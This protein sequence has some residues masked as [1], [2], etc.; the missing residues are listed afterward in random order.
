MVH[1][2]LEK[3]CDAKRQ[4]MDKLN[5]QGKKKGAIQKRVKKNNLQ[6]AV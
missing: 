3:Y 1:N 5:L 6:T 4:K 2:I